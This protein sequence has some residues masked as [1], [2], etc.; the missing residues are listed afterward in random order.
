MRPIGTRRVRATRPRFVPELAFTSP[1]VA[2]ISTS[3]TAVDGH[4]AGAVNDITFTV[5]GIE[6]LP[7]TDLWLRWSDAQL[8]SNA[9]DGLGIDNVEFSAVP[10]PAGLAAAGAGR[11]FYRRPPS[12]PHAVS[13]DA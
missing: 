3:G 9:D 12:P 5:T 8:A 13:D 10:E 1:V 7:G 11:G 2:G 6:W 4:T